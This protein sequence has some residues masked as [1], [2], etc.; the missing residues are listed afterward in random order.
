MNIKDIIRKAITEALLKMNIDNVDV[1]LEVPGDKS[2]GDY[3]TNVAMKLAS[4]MKQNPKEIAN[5]IK[6][7]I[8]T[9][10]YIENIEVAGP[11]FLNFFLKKTALFN[12][13]EEVIK[14]SGNYGKSNIGQ[15][16]KINVE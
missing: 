12:L 9:N 3:A 13:I 15:G 1:E 11:G 14:Q 8:S 7:H 10:E 2:N 4:Y 6:D 5:T 16:Q